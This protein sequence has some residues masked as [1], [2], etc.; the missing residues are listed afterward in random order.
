MRL[1]SVVPFALNSAAVSIERGHVLVRNGDVLGIRFAVQFAADA[2]ASL[3]VSSTNQV[4][5]CGEAGGS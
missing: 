2:Q 5:E 3:G 1:D 4:H